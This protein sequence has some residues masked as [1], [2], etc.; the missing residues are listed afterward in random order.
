MKFLFLTILCW[1]YQMFWNP[2]DSFDNRKKEKDE[3]IIMAAIAFAIGNEV[4]KR[5]EK[6][7]K[8]V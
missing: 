3:A 2:Y 8:K 7:E 4:F 1:I 5:E 6:E